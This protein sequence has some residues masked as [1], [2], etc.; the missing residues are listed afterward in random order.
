LRWLDVIL[1]GMQRLQRSFVLGIAGQVVFGHVVFGCARGLND[2]GEDDAGVPDFNA[3]EGGV[4]TKDGGSSRKDSGSVPDEDAG[5]LDA[6]APDTGTMPSACQTRLAALTYGFDATTQGFT[7]VILDGQSGTSWPFNPW[8]HGIAANGAAC[9]SGSCFA[10]ELTQ[11][12]AQC[13]RGALVS[14]PIDLTACS[15]ESTTKLSFYHTFDFKKFTYAGVGYADG[16][17]V[18]ISGDGGAT[19][20]LAAP[21]TSNGTVSTNQGGSFSCLDSNNFSVNGKAGFTGLSAS[22]TR[23]VVEIPKA[24]RTANFRVRFAM[25]SGVSSQTTSASTSRASTGKGWRIDDI[26]FSL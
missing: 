15:S 17:I 2:D 8:S 24:L 3:A 22:F 6:A 21:A 16:G 25:S 26:A 7:S 11:N 5:V 4:Q 12:Y 23:A 20:Q 14:P 19:W 10:A 18:E 1:K 13:Q 9:R